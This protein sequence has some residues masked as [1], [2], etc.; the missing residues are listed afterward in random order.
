MSPNTPL[1]TDALSIAKVI[2]LKS[3]NERPFETARSHNNLYVRVF[4]CCLFDRV[5]EPARYAS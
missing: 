2:L 5:E 4:L 3:A 1:V